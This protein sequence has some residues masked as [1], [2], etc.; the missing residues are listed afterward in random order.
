MGYSGTGNRFRT[1]K[2]DWFGE[3]IIT[4]VRFYY[5]DSWRA[6]KQKDRCITRKLN[7]GSGTQVKE[8]IWNLRFV[9]WDLILVLCLSVE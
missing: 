9:V 8:I 7:E 2:N 1:H 5:D 6:N 4:Q 3:E